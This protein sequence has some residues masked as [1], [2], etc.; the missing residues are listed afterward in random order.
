VPTEK[1]REGERVIVNLCVKR[2][3]QRGEREGKK[4]SR[5]PTPFSVKVKRKKVHCST[6]GGGEEGKKRSK[7]HSFPWNRE[8]EGKRVLLLPWRTWGEKGRDEANTSERI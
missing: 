4:K 7:T 1:E 3:V 5:G 2:H 8:R 6:L